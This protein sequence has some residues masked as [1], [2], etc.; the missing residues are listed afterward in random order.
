MAALPQPSPAPDEAIQL[1]LEKLEALG[2]SLAKTRDEAIQARQASGIEDIW[3]EDEEHYEGIDDANRGADRTNYSTKPPGQARPKVAETQSTEFVNITRPYVDAAAAKV[4]DIL[5]PTDEQAWSLKPTPIPE[6]IDKADGKLPPETQEGIQQHLGANGVPPAQQQQALAQVA[7]N[8]A[9]E[10]AKTL[11]AAKDAAE[12]AET[13][14][15]DWM[16]EGQWHGEVRKVI[17]DCCRIGSGVLKGPIPE[18]KRTQAYKDGALI[19]QE[20]IK[21]T[22]RRIDPKNFY[23]DGGCGDS[24]HNGRYTWEVDYIT[25]KQLAALKADPDYISETVDLCLEEGPKHAGESRKTTDGL[26]VPD[27]DLFQIWYYHGYALREDLEAAGCECQPDQQIN[28][29]AV[30]TM[31]NDR[32]IKGT[33]NPLDTGDFPYDVIPWQRRKN[34]PWGTGV[35]RQIRTPQRMVLGAS[36]TL[37]TNAGRAAGPIFVL[38]NGVITP[39]DGAMEITPWK[40]FY[41]GESDT[42]DDVS[43]CMTMFTIP[44]MRESLMAIIQW[45]LKLAEDVTGLPM[46]LQGQQGGAPDTLGGQQLLD[47]NASGVLRRIAR[48]FDDCITEPHV[49]RYYAWLLQYGEDDEKGEFVIDAKGSTALVDRDNERQQIQGLLGASLNPAYGLSPKKLM[50]E[51]LRANKRNPDDLMY[52]DD[53]LK[54]MQQ[55]QPPPNPAVQVATIKEQGATQRQQAEQQFEAKENAQDRQVDLLTIA[56]EERQVGMKVQG[57]KEITVEELKADLAG[58]TMTLTTQDRLNARD[59]AHEKDIAVAAHKIDV[60]KHRTKPK[61]PMGQKPTVVAKPPTEP[62]G[63]APNGQSYE[64]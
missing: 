42:T 8:E 2:K 38:K 24:I 21:P 54:A 27:K 34:M 48:T 60:H 20:E 44:D 19:I 37:L 13:R 53:E 59:I 4:G 41:A 52:S 62:V 26:D 22:S 33:L 25:P 15:A 50:T 43:K 55:Q 5:L 64:R 23:P 61:P 7:Q 32:V 56:G 40:M 1:T 46:L 3:R 11:Q 16:I 39:A 31:V 63:R 57:E 36:R 51:L 47:R 10:A 49:R 45:G 30:F 12:K 29:P 17:D 28:I 9:A 35:G 58:K 14:I 6:L 18:A